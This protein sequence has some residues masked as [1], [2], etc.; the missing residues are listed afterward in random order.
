[1]SFSH[2]SNLPLE[3][4]KTIILGKLYIMVLLFFLMES[5][6]TKTM[7]NN[8]LKPLRKSERKDHIEERRW[9]FQSQSGLE[10]DIWYLNILDLFFLN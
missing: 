6:I 4:V 7:K 9:D 3:D 5:L 2:I 1:M 10:M 8:A